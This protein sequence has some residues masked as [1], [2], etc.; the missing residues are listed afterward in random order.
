[1]RNTYFG[2]ADATQLTDDYVVAG[3][4][5]LSRAIA[6]PR[7]YAD[8]PPLGKP[9]NSGAFEMHA[10]VI[11]NLRSHCRRLSL[12]QHGLKLVRHESAVR[13]L[14]DEDE[15]TR[16]YYA[17]TAQLLARETRASRVVV[18]DHTIRGRLPPGISG[19]HRSPVTNVHVDYTIDSATRRVRALMG[20][21]AEGL[22]RRRVAIM[23]VW[24][25]IRAPL[26]EWPLAVA[27]AASIEL[28]ELVVADL[29]Y[30]DRTGGIYY[31]TYSPSHRWFYVPSM[32]VDEVLIFK[33]YDSDNRC[34]GRFAAHCAFEDP[35]KWPAVES[36]ASVEARAVVFWG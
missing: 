8:E 11:S 15:V 23:N 5:Y 34:A 33:N 26:R 6:R 17:E 32:Q 1:M 10:M 9:R 12:D 36:R 28:G 3:L 18:F 35:T 7:V 25:P 19:N 29:I 27:D 13:N 24:R 2:Q 14:L 30:P 21:E 31:V 16:V 22:L 20:E 4:N